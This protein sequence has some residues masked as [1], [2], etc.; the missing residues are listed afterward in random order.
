[1][2]DMPNKDSDKN[3]GNR[4]NKKR[5]EKNIKGKLVY[6]SKTI[7]LKEN[8]MNKKIKMVTIK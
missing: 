1:M 3:I 2:S 8:I 7:R 6:N 5:R 4:G